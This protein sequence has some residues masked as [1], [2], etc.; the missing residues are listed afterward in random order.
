MS[1]TPFD[2][3]QWADADDKLRHSMRRAES[4]WRQRV[5]VEGLLVT[6][7]VVIVA[8]NAMVLATGLL[9]VTPESFVLL[10]VVF[11]LI[12]IAAIGW[13]LVRPAVRRIS[14]ADLARYLEEREPSFGQALLSA[15]GQATLPP[16]ARTSPSLARRL[17]SQAATALETIEAGRALERPRMRRALMMLVALAAAGA[18]LL[19][20][21]PASWRNLAAGFLFPWTPP[22]EVVTARRLMVSPG[23]I[24]LPRG[25]SLDISIEAQGFEPGDAVLYLREASAEEWDVV[26]M[27]RDADGRFSVRLFDLDS[28]FTYRIRA[29][30]VESSPHRV[31]ITDLPAVRELELRLEYPSYSGLPADTMTGGGDVAA[32]VGT[33]VEV[34][35]S[36]TMPVGA[37]MLRFDDG[38]RVPLAII[39]SLQPM[40]RFRVSRNGFYSIE[41]V[42]PDGTVVPGNVRWAV[43]ALPDRPPVVRVTEP[44][45]DVRATNVEE[46]PIAMSAD[47][48]F[49]VRSLELRFTINGGDEQKLSLGAGY[50]AGTLTPREV[51]TLFLEEYPLSAG[52][53]VAYYA[54]AID[55]A[56]NEARSDIYFVEIR[57][58]SRNYRQAEQGG[59]GGGGGMGGSGDEPELSRV[60]RELIVA[61][62]NVLRDSSSVDP[63]RLRE[64]VTAIAVNQERLLDR[65]RELAT[66]I[67]TRGAVSV[68]STFL[69]IAAALDSSAT[70]ME[71]ALEKLRAAR[72][73]EALPSTQQA[74]RQLQRS[75][76]LYRDVQLQLG[77]QAGGGGGGGGAPEDLADLFELNRDQLRNQYEAVQREASGGSGTA[78]E[79]DEAQQR[80]RDLARRL[81]QE[82]ERQRRMAEA[83]NQR[84]GQQAG[85]E[86]GSGGSG[87]SGGS[88]GAQSR[89]S[90]TQRRFAEEAEAEA[91]R[92]ERLAREQ[93]TPELE[94]AAQAARQAADAMRR[95]AAGEAGRQE[96]AAE[97]LRNALENVGAGQESRARRESERLGR[98]AADLAR[99][100]RELTRNAAA[101]PR[102]ASN[103]R[104]E[105]VR[106]LRQE[107]QRLSREAADL[108]QELERLSRELR[109]NDPA[110]AA[111]LA[112]GAQRMREFQ[113][114][115]RIGQGSGFIGDD[116]IDPGA[117]ERYNNQITAVLEEVRDRVGLA[118]GAVGNS[119]ERRQARALEQARELTRALDAINRR[120]EMARDSGQGQGQQ[121]QQPGQEG[122]E[123]G[124]PNQQ[125]GQPGDQGQQPGQGG[126]PGQGEDRGQGE[127]QQSG[128]QAGGV[129][130]GGQPQG[131]SD[132][133]QLS[134][135]VRAR[136]GA[137]EALRQELRDQGVTVT[138]L[139][140]A[141]SAMRRLQ[142]DRVQ[143]DPLEMARLVEDALESLRQAEFELWRKFSGGTESLP[144]V[145]DLSRVSP[146]Y[147]A[148]VE[149]YYRSI[150]R[151]R[152]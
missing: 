137:A 136:L 141:I 28:S 84:L 125:S 114:P 20:L 27:A 12:C 117:L 135:E 79:I 56:G 4:A 134:R 71:E 83:M 101:L 73:N 69:E 59:G 145:G 144:A 22:G 75:E 89:N 76:A 111:A 85:S 115:E 10:R 98:E 142:Q 132:A 86:G 36:L 131:G 93:R 32:V 64:D 45:R 46:L 108:Q 106:R 119:P 40:A 21:G 143:G 17:M 82:N 97:S 152:Q 25:A 49:G 139:D 13:L 26:P 138:S 109:S 147:R 95:A 42:A 105:E 2:A 72:L 122:Q 127:Q 15:V 9:R 68:D 126:R 88:A 103:T 140:E 14:P 19:G 151:D 5:V 78:R 43:D 123:R 6:A 61:T 65:V 112:E 58:F 47:D 104:P 81:E 128:A 124:Q 7:I 90:A 96:Q 118:A 92:L 34:R 8:L 149:E 74:L 33:V 100:Q 1:G 133:R 23:N 41:L 53:L 146:R 31:T 116:R 55:G 54:A 67:V 129:P 44:G 150:A 130:T 57:P 120:N 62:Y 91:R 52:D 107:G 148:L 80:L 38:T 3:T 30:D 66:E 110:A 102:G 50:P 60:Q 35:P 11:L 94:Q 99:E 16:E 24:T 113:I 39:D 37:G 77:E 51:H 87:T 70:A 18:V 63:S 48:D 121:G 29:D